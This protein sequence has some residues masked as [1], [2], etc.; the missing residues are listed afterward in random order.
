MRKAFYLLISI[1]FFISCKKEKQ[2][3]LHQEKQS[4]VVWQSYDETKDIATTQK[5]EENRMHLKLIN[6]KVQDKN[7]IWSALEIELNL[8]SETKY[9]KLK[10]FI[11]EKDIPTIQQYIKNGE[12]TYEE[13]TL[14]YIYRIRKYESD[15]SVS[16]NSVISLNP[17]VVEQARTLDKV[18]KK[19]IDAYSV[20]GM[21]ILLKDNI[22]TEDMVT[23]A[24]AVALQDNKTNNA[25]ITSRLV[26]ENALILGKAN[27]SEWAYFLC[28]GCPVGY[29][30]IGGQTLNPYGRLVFETGG[31]SSGSGVAVAA[32][33]CVAAVGTET[34]GSILSPSSQ[35]SVVGLKPTIGVLSRTGIVPISSTLDTPGP[36]SKNVIDT[37]ILLNALLGKDLKDNVS[38]DIDV[39]FVNA[40]KQSSLKGKRFGVVKELL[41]D[42]L[43]NKAIKKIR[44]AG[45]E[46][47]EI[48]PKEVELPGFLNIL[49]IDMKND[50]P[51]YISSESKGGVTVKNIEDV[52]AFNLTDTIISIPYGQQLFEGIVVDST[53]NQELSEIKENLKTIARNYFDMFLDKHELDAILSINNYHAGYAAVAKYPAITIPMGYTDKGEPKG[54]TFIAKP[55]SEK[56]L[57]QLGY[58]YEQ[59]TKERKQPVNYLN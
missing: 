58:G 8:F 51:R 19:N 11:L 45:G 52:I 50:L 1:F 6:S 40:I 29:S 56:L 17:K 35:N 16:L 28:S 26:G 34:S 39:D 22:G 48:E 53:T 12:F 24:G 43:Y 38:V 36:M 33:F 42:S 5:L 20:F 47:T 13:L 37:A 7:N 3:E 4:K 18:D 9:N 59:E 14:F 32:N 23:T 21:P 31:S 44:K 54:L 30:A 57:L 25:Y 27:L 46:I 55:F 2:S 10:G 15:N 41:E 49:N